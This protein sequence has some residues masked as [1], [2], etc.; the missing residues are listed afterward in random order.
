MSRPIQ[1]IDKYEAS[2][3]VIAV[4]EKRLQLINTLLGE[5]FIPSSIRSIWDRDEF[6]SGEFPIDKTVFGYLITPIYAVIAS[7]DAELANR[8]LDAGYQALPSDLSC[9][10]YEDEHILSQF[11]LHFPPSKDSSQWT[12]HLLHTTIMYNMIQRSQE[13]ILHIDNFDYSIG[14]ET[15]LQ[16]A[17]RLGNTSLVDLLIK[18][19]ADVNAI[20]S[21]RSGNKTPLQIAVE[22]GN[23]S[24]VD[25]LIK[26]GADVNAPALGGLGNGSATALQLAAIKG[27]MEVAR[28]LLEYGG[29]VNGLPARIH[30]RT[31][32]EG[33]SE[34]GKLD[35]VQLLLENG[36][37]L[38][39][40]MRIHYIRA[41]AYAR[42]EGHYAVA[43]LLKEFGPWTN[44]D[45]EVYNREDILNDQGYFLFDTET[46][47]WHFHKV[48]TILK[49]R[50][51][52]DDDSTIYTETLRSSKGN[53]PSSNSSSDDGE[54]EYNQTD[55]DDGPGDA[56]QEQSDCFETYEPER[57]EED[58]GLLLERYLKESFNYDLNDFEPDE[59]EFRDR[60]IRNPDNDLGTAIQEEQ[61]DGHEANMLDWWEL[62]I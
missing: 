16:L 2:A 56:I 58:A 60:Y 4:R 31:A 36:A 38:D 55:S 26:A 33:A 32:L 19:K 37:S 44:K 59:H 21:K 30:G 20:A 1:T 48:W 9:L 27:N 61:Y 51:G 10:E 28:S 53:S 8:I 57:E 24:L 54:S 46:Q 18:A 3:L 34:H 7:G 39:G 5:R 45:Q 6:D 11:W 52:D 13:C 47:D 22:L 49:K 62:E 50:P 42:K 14:Y 12:R 40:A 35:M 41:V 29:D 15:P 43:T 25:A 23:T 17:V